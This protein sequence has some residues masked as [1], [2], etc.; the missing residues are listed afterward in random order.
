[1]VRYHLLLAT[2]LGLLAAAGIAAS[3]LRL[4]GE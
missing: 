4:S 1:M 2:L 3:D